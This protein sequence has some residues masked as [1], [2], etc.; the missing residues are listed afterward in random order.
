MKINLM[1]LTEYKKHNI[2]NV[3]KDKNDQ[4]STNKKT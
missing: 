1:I 4:R 2:I 3:T